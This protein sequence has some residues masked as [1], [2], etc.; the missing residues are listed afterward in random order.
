[1]KISQVIEIFDSD[2]DGFY[3]EQHYE[4]EDGEHIDDSMLGKRSMDNLPEISDMRQNMPLLSPGALYAK[5][6]S[7]FDTYDR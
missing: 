2:G 3:Y 6:R 7:L 5:K 1:M 4:N